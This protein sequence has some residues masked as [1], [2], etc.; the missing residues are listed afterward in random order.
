MKDMRDLD[1]GVGDLVVVSGGTSRLETGV[2]ETVSETS[3]TAVFN[4]KVGPEPVN[5]WEDVVLL[6]PSERS[7][8]V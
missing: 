6:K 5:S 4:S 7:E 3:L 1:I 8:E 2:V